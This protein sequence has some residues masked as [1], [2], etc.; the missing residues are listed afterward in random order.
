MAGQAAETYTD[1]MLGDPPAAITPFEA[2]TLDFVFGAVWSRPGLSRRQRRLVTLA[3]ACA[4]DAVAP[5]NDHMYGA[6]ASSDLSRDELLE[7]VLH[8]AVYCGWPKA[9]QAE[10]SLRT[11]FA[12]LCDERGEEVQ[13][14]PPLDNASLGP[15]DHE[16]RLA[17][18]EACFAE[19]NLWPPPPRD[20]PYFQAGIL[21]FVFGHLW[22]RPNLGRIDRRFITIACVGLSDAL[23]P[24]HS[25]VGSALRSGDITV[26]EMDEVIL[27]FSAYYGFAKGQVLHDAVRQT[28]AQL[29][30]ERADGQAPQPDT[31]R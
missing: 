9:S 13:P 25:H 31:S 21:G 27:Q 17:G 10:M 11:A 14:W 3:C 20:S 12:Q 22:Q 6:L 23:G 16:S 18:G 8:F 29:E 7:F 2:A 19:V 28:Q 5:I 4:A 24:I 1:V 26:A 30:A 15:T